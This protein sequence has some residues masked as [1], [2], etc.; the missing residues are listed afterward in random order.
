MST[1]G[2]DIRTKAYTYIYMYIC[3]AY[4]RYEP[5]YQLDGAKARKTLATPTS[6]H[7]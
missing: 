2:L 3:I 1:K 4:N 7:I 5:P 6:K